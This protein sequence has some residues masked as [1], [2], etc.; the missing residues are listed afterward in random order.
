MACGLIPLLGLTLEEVE[1]GSTTKLAG[2]LIVVSLHLK[3]DMEC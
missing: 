2:T 3:H 1:S